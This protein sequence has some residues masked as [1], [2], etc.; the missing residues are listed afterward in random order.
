MLGIVLKIL[1]I[2]G[3]VL[4]TLLLLAVLAVLLVLFF[5]FTYRVRGSRDEKGLRLQGK[6]NWL[7]GLFRVRYRY[8]E[9]G[10]LTAKALWFPLLDLKL[11]PDKPQEQAGEANDGQAQEGGAEPAEKEDRVQGGKA[12]DGNSVAAGL[13]NPQS[14]VPEASEPSEQDSGKKEPEVGNGADRKGNRASE[15]ASGNAQGENAPEDESAG[16]F[17]KISQKLQKIRYTIYGIYD[18]IKKIWENI[19]YYIELLQEENTKLL[20]AHAAKRVRQI[21]KSVRPRHIRTRLLFGTGSPDTTG[22]LYGA[23]CMASALYGRDF[24]VTPD[25]ERKIFQG[26]FDIAGHVIVWVFVVNGAKLLL[27]RK[28]RWFLK[29]LKRGRSKA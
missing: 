26:E 28:L 29:K 4:L 19:S 6:V 20:T 25:F 1:S 10:H 3:I 23:Y 5:P 12:A 21:L 16:I 22:Y 9:S 14:R 17:G 11:P 18:K 15:D 13:P 27:D 2:V 7:F 8:P 24:A